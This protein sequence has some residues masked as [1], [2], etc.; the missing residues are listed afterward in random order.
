MDGLGDDA[1]LTLRGDHTA[2]VA[3][4]TVDGLATVGVTS[5]RADKHWVVAS[6]RA[7]AEF[8]GD[9]LATDP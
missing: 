7:L 2:Q 5:L 8:A 6:A 9:H 4:L 1:F 3:W